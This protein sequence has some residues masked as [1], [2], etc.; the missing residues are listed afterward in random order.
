MIKNANYLT[1][2]KGYWYGW[3]MLPGYVADYSPYFSPIFVTDVKPL[4]SGKNVLK[5]QFLNAHY[6]QGVADFDLNL[7]VLKKETSY[8]VSEILHGYEHSNR[9]GIISTIDEAWMELFAPYMWKTHR[10]HKTCTPKD[11]IQ[12]FL[13]ECYLPRAMWR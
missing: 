10:N 13:D 12:R 5:L 6:A 7:K 3:Q 4:K 2:E 8:I 11:N 1:L 9:S